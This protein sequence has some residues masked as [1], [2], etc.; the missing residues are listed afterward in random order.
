MRILLLLLL[1]TVITLFV[2]VRA[3]QP[4]QP[5]RIGVS[6]SRDG[7]FRLAGETYERGI[8]LWLNDVNARGGMLGRMV[9]LVIKD[10][11]SDPAKA[12]EAYG[13]LAEKR[14]SDLL[15]GPVSMV[16]TPWA[17]PALERSNAPCVIPVAA[18]DTLWKDGKGL[19]FGVLSPLSEW[20]SGFFEVISKAGL[21]HV[22]LL[23]VDHPSS[24]TVLEDSSKLAKRYGLDVAVKLSTDLAGLPGAI[25]QI[26]QAKADAVAVWGSPEGCSEALCELRRSKWKIKAVYMS[27]NIPPGTLPLKP[28]DNLDGVFTALPWDIRAAGAYPGSSH[29][30]ESFRAAYGQDP[31]PLAASAFAG[32]QV[33]E[34]AVTRAQ[35][36]DRQKLRKALAKLD[37]LTIIGRYGVD[38][39][40]MQLRQFPLTVQWQK[41]KREI[42]WPWQLRTAKPAVER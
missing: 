33:L 2:I 12:A 18:S 29:F 34:A 9:E 38:Q 11:H 32:C 4:D 30:V 21:E 25:R 20:S 7:T 22:A 35:S 41:G 6:I 37:I 5:I 14:E 19:A 23:V 31:D 40:G 15:L 16:L 24:E 36:L 8:R 10:D 28:G 42:V 17:I 3:V 26:S 13:E 39:S 1:A 27:A